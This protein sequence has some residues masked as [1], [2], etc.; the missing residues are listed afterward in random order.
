[1]GYSNNGKNSGCTH[2]HLE[3][4]PFGIYQDFKRYKYQIFLD[5]LVEMVDMQDD[6]RELQNRR[7]ESP[8]GLYG[9]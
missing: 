8:D 7:P 3:K 5:E 6:L 9:W 1:M 4:S 2:K